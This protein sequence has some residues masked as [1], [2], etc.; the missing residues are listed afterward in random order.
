MIH[1]PIEENEPKVSSS[2]GIGTESAT[3]FSTSTFSA[4][5]YMEGKGD[6][7]H[8]IFD[9][10]LYNG[11]HEFSTAYKYPPFRNQKF[12]SV[13]GNT[14][15][16]PTLAVRRD[17]LQRIV[18]NSNP[19][20][21]WDLLFNNNTSAHPSNMRT[22]N[23]K[24]HLSTN[25][26]IFS[27]CWWASL[28]TW[29]MQAEAQYA[30]K[31]VTQDTTKDEHVLTRHDIVAIDNG[32][33]ECSISRLFIF[34]KKNILKFVIDS[35]AEIFVLPAIKLCNEMNSS[36]ILILRADG[37]SIRTYC[38]N[39]LNL[40]KSSPRNSLCISNSWGFKTNYWCSFPQ[41]IWS[42]VLD[43]GLSQ[44][45]SHALD[46]AATR[47]WG[48]TPMKDNGCRRDVRLIDLRQCGD[49]LNRNIHFKSCSIMPPWVPPSGFKLISCFVALITIGIF[50]SSEFLVVVSSPDHDT[51]ALGDNHLRTH[52]HTN[53]F[54]VIG[55]QM[56]F[57][58]DDSSK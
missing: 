8:S 14:T 1:V 13:T 47:I 54:H 55:D 40:N 42:R 25:R 17:K 23:F 18:T 29:G 57:D 20:N 35:G 11:L 36:D 4:S 37:S 22:V 28:E 58:D 44:F 19:N 26:Q 16:T 31:G 7:M 9:L 41:K 45:T 51:S 3:L 53:I 38:K 2:E 56:D 32:I 12:W 33:F 10:S 21:I 48:G 5:P 50:A 24:R 39:L 27:C 52:P 6:A 43:S 15:T 30:S 34:D 49:K 46:L